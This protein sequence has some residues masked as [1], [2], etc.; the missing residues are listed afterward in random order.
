MVLDGHQTNLRHRA[1]V[2][3]HTKPFSISHDLFLFSGCKR[4]SYIYRNFGARNNN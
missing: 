1:T 3:L 2:H 4:L